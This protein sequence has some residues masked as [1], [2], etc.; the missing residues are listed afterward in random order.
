MLRNSRQT[1]KNLLN[2]EPAKINKKVKKIL[3]HRVGPSEAIV[4]E[5]GNWLR[6]LCVRALVFECYHKL[7]F[8]KV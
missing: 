1:E 5:D 6:M 3:C 4:I 8:R 7:A 2:L